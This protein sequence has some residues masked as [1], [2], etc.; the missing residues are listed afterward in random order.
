MNL[1]MSNN[2]NTEAM[3]AP[4]SCPA[5]LSEGVMFSHVQPKL[6]IASANPAIGLGSLAAWD[7]QRLRFEVILNT[8]QY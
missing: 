8:S 4:V 1:P 6:A 2:S 3:M 7:V 5:P